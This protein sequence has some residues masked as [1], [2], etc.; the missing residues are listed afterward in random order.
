MSTEI[1]LNLTA[2]V[3]PFVVKGDKDYNLTQLILPVRMD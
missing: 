3:R 2:E 1:T